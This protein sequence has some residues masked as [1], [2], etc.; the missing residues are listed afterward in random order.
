MELEK[1]QNVSAPV[2]AEA[3]K[4]LS[5]GMYREAGVS[6]LMKR[7]ERFAML[8]QDNVATND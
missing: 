4:V 6:L 2:A 1:I 5:F 8:V 3:M 7:A